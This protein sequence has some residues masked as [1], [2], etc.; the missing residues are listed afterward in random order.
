MIAIAVV[1]SL[2][3]YA[4]VSGYLGFQT[5]KAGKAIQ[6]PSFALNSDNSM[7]VYAQNVG[8]G[9]V[10]IGPVYVDDEQKVDFTNDASKQIGEGDTVSLTI[11]GSYNKD[12]RYDIKVT[13]T[14]GTSMT[15]SNVKPGTGTQGGSG[16]ETPVSVTFQTA[17][18]G[19]GS[20]DPSGTASYNVGTSFTATATLTGGSTFGGWSAAP[21]GSVTFG[22]ANDAQT[23]VTINAAGTVT[24]TINPPAGPTTG[25]III[26]QDS[27]PNAA[28]SFAFNGDNGIGAFNLV[29]DGTSSASQTFSGLAPNTYTI[30]QSAVSGWT[31]ASITGATSSNVGTRTATVTVVAGNTYTV[32][33][34]N[35]QNQPDYVDTRTVPIPVG[36]EN[37]WANMYDTSTGTYNTLTEANTGT[38]NQWISP[39]GYYTSNWNNE[40]NAY[41]E[42][43]TSA[44][45]Y[46]V[47]DGRWSDYLTLTYPSTTGTKIRYYV[48]TESTSINTVEISVYNTATSSW[49]SVYSGAPTTNQWVEVSFTS[50]TTNAISFR[51]YNNNNDN[52]RY[53][54]VYEVDIQSD[55][56]PNNSLDYQVQFQDIASGYTQLEIATGSFTGSPSETIAVYG[57]VSSG[58]WTLIDNSLTASSSTA[59]VYTL[60][61]TLIGTTLQLRFVDGTQSSDA[62]QNSWQI[63]YVRLVKP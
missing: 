22:N 13:T 32:T 55:G 20:V 59:N 49:Q 7:T 14:D 1:A 57:R 34:A 24:A 28:Q 35:T 52:Y 11:P 26:V 6:I 18:T 2:V 19:T 3:V 33:F 48:A 16:G 40:G 58:S 23:T 37:N 36:T 56:I 15:L 43:T 50:R 42:S 17:G 30:T 54:N 62:T 9:T 39:T 21:V 12:T 8:Q 46:D 29:D 5:G 10:Q 25:T 27:Q 61:P 31:L 60:P 51:F 44:A 38:S 53:V 4:W 63:D 47:R 45:Y 41:D